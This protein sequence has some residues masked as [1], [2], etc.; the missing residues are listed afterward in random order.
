[1]YD[2]TVVLVAGGAPS[3]AVAPIEVFN[4]AGILWNELYGQPAHPLFRLQTVSLD[5]R[6][7]QTGFGLHLDP[8]GCIDDVGNTD[9]IVLAAVGVDIASAAPAHACLYPWLR[10]W[11]R[12]GTWIAGACAGTA[13]IAESGLLDD[14]VATTHWGVVET[15]RRRYPR[16]RW[17]P[18]RILTEANHVVC[19]GGVYAAVDLSLYLVEK[20]YGH[21]IAL[22]TAK[23]LVLETPRT[24]QIGYAAEP[25]NAS[26]GDERIAQAQEW[27]FRHFDQPLSINRLAAQ[28]CMSPRNFGR[29]FKTA[30]GQTPMAYVHQLRI[31]VARQLLE[32]ERR[33]VQEVSGAVG[34]GDVTYFRELF[35]Q[36]TG[37]SPQAYR[38]RY[39]IGP[40]Q[41][42][43]LEGL[44]SE[45]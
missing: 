36:Q 22:Q 42:T 1:M 11:H 6:A 26:H 3:T 44:D 38:R 24:W 10:H 27:L 7:V 28:A 18:E 12:Q 32:S 2:V 9:L 8:D 34:Y 5:G 37:M 20:C 40:T 29:R 25:P 16:V 41:K 21:R 45:C 15:C 23:A 33:T 4:S 39:A 30:T 13:L 35:R 31:N 14:Q 19:G 43:V 17:Q